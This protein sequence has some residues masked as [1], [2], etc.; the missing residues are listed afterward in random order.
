M[1]LKHIREDL[2]RSGD[3]GEERAKNHAAGAHIAK[4]DP[5]A[6]N[7]PIGAAGLLWIKRLAI[8]FRQR[9]RQAELDPSQVQHRRLFLQFLTLHRVIF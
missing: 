9:L 8:G 7:L 3:K 4:R 1:L 5:S 6:Q 2:F